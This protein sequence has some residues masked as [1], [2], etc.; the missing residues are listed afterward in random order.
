MV[1]KLVGSFIRRRDRQLA[2]AIH[3]LFTCFPFAVMWLEGERFVVKEMIQQLVGT[4]GR[5]KRKK[6][7]NEG[8]MR[9]NLE[10]L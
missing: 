10:S 3:T 4:G 9:I 6:Y 1:L 7:T 8:E 2:T 5:I